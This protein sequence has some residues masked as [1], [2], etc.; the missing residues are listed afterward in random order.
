M[1]SKYF[2]KNPSTKKERFKKV[3]SPKEND[4]IPSYGSVNLKSV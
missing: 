3:V 1:K 4:R 2:P